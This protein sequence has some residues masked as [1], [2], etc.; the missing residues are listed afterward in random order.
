MFFAIE[1][2]TFSSPDSQMDFCHDTQ[3]HF[4]RG[5]NSTAPFQYY[6]LDFYFANARMEL[7][8]KC[9]DKTPTQTYLN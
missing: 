8:T 9:F 5:S 6:L 2:E 4:T 1:I 7:L 3:C